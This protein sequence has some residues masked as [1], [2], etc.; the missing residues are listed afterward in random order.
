MSF[1]GENRKGAFRRAPGGT[2]L[3]RVRPTRAAH[4]TRP[5]V[6]RAVAG[7]RGLSCHARCEDGE[8]LLHFGGAAMR[9]FGAL[10]IAGADEHFAIFVA[11]VAMKFV[12]RHGRTLLKNHSPFQSHPPSTSTERSSPFSHSTATRKGRQHTSQSV[13]NCCDARFVSSNSVDTCPQ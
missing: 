6:P 10:P 5:W 1:S 8:S 13:V 2:G 9:A 12:K 11:G 7:G 4:S 3:M